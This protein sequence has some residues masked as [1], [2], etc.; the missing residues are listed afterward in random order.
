AH[1]SRTALRGRIDLRLRK[2]TAA[3]GESADDAQSEN[4]LHSDSPVGGC[5][6]AH[7]AASTSPVSV[8]HRDRTPAKTL[9][10]AAPVVAIARDD[11]SWAPHVTFDLDGRSEPLARD[12]FARFCEDAAARGLGLQIA[13]ESRTHK[14][15]PR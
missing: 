10:F 7:G 6:C 13:H 11:V 15:S 9:K 12:E 1:G 5:A 14:R 2:K 8:L 3:H 4:S